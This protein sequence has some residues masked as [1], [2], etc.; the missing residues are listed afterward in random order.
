[1]QIFI[2]NKISLVIAIGKFIFTFIMQQIQLLSFLSFNL[3]FSPFVANNH[4]L[5]KFYH[6]N[7]LRNKE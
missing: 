4:C 1:M 7:L 2:S 5:K 3:Y 6:W